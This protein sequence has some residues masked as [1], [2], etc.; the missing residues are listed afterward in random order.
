MKIQVAVR[1]DVGRRRQNNEDRPL[2]DES[3]GL[4]VVCDGMGGAAAGEA[5]SALAAATVQQTI[6]AAAGHET[7]TGEVTPEESARIEEVVRSAL[8]NAN[9]RVHELGKQDS[10]KKGAGST[11]TALLIRRGRAFLGHVG[12]SRAYLR[13]QGQVHRLTA[14][15]SVVEQAI[16]RGMPREEAEAQFASNVLIR[17]IG[18]KSIVVVD[19]LAFDVLPGD[20]YLLCSDGLYDYFPD[21]DGEIGPMLDESQLELIPERLVDMANQRGGKDNITAVVVRIHGL[22]EDLQRTSQVQHD[23]AALSRMQLFQ[24]MSYSE[25]LELADSLHAQIFDS[26]E[27]II[28]EG[29]SSDSL[30]VISTGAVQVE[31]G[32][33][34]ITTL[35][36]GAHFG[37]M[38][39]L[40]DRP[41]TATVRAAEP[42]RVLA[43]SRER[44][45]AL[46]SRLPAIGM[47]FL[48]NL[49]QVQSIRLDEALL[50][51]AQAPP[52]A[53]GAAP[54][55]EAGVRST[56]PVGTVIQSD[57]WAD[58][59]TQ[60]LPPPLG[61]TRSR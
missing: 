6:A 15:H 21:T 28:S 47:K 18:P 4:Y 7:M 2:V 57:G 34:A 42:T 45:N 55:P 19:T 5:A 13:R 22:D 35:G 3:L 16:L 23:L 53:P 50:W 52:S 36:P 39:V 32:G 30:Y 20:T 41:R 37:E 58:E 1:T 25:L 31:R 29:E 51:R 27:P 12:D 59:E 38:S 8:E 17:A 43:L 11:C 60:L 24:A 10:S 54:A 40:T 26:G 49:A 9:A 61:D 48:W 46:F 44:L 14:D 33:Q 56:L